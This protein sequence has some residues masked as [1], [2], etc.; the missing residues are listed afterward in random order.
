MYKYLKA[1]TDVKLLTFLKKN[2]GGRKA[3]DHKIDL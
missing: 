3:V 2:G 1:S